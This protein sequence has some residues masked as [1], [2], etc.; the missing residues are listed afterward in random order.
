MGSINLPSENCC[1]RNTARGSRRLL[2]LVKCY[3]FFSVK[4]N[5]FFTYCNERI[6]FTRHDKQLCAS[7]QGPVLLFSGLMRPA[8]VVIKRSVDPEN[9]LN[10]FVND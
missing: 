3:L 10:G 4:Y 5:S 9:R 7:T 8:S 1:L 2:L 6:K